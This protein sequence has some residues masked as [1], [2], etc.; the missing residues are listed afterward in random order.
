[1]Y[2]ATNTNLL[3]ALHCKCRFLGEGSTL[4]PCLNPPSL[5]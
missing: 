3:P 2:Q 4:L 1:M 5:F